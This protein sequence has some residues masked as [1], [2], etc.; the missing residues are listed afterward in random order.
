MLNRFP[1]AVRAPEDAP[2]GA[3][4]TLMGQAAQTPPEGASEAAPPPAEKPENTGLN[5]DG[6]MKPGERP[7]WLP[8]KFWDEEGKLP[9]TQE[10][11]KSYAEIE[12]LARAKKED[13]LK[14]AQAEARKG[15]PETPDAY[16]IKLDPAVIPAGDNLQFDDKSPMLAFWR[17]K[18]HEMG[19]SQEGFNEGV[20][21]YLR[22]QIAAQPDLAPERA[23]LGENHAERIRIADE[24]AFANFPLRAY[25]AISKAST[26]HGMVL[27]VEHMMAAYG[28]APPPRAA[29]PVASADPKSVLAEAMSKPGYFQDQEAQARVRRAFEAA[30]GRA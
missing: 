28:T 14:A 29:G 25:Q 12:K 13:V 16:E 5:A 23:A 20:N 24:W 18:A 15:V 4:P 9:R 6:S 17:G 27:A 2:A 1:F 19:L 11:A 26:D 3:T 7:D 8:A 10:M 21:A 30:S 22:E